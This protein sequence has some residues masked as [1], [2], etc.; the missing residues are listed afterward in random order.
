MERLGKVE[1][2]LTN[3][4]GGNVPQIGSRAP[5]PVCFSVFGF[6]ICTCDPLI[7]LGFAVCRYPFVETICFSTRQRKS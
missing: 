7:L 3:E 6:H 4:K 1:I 2:I 5:V